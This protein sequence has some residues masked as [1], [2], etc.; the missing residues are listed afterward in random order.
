MPGCMHPSCMHLGWSNNAC[1]HVL[2]NRHICAYV[3]CICLHT[4][5]SMYICI[6]HMVAYMHV[7]HTYAL[8]TCM[9]ACMYVCTYGCALRVCAHK[10]VSSVFTQ[11]HANLRGLGICMCVPIYIQP[12]VVCLNTNPCVFVMHANLCM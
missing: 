9:R 12:R 6:I 8:C 1:K 4:C 2:I 5:M 3:Q 10:G 11:M 7:Y